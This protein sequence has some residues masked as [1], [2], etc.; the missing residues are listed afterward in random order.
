ML[1]SAADA[2][3]LTYAPGLTELAGT[4]WAATGI[5]NGKEAVVS[6]AGTEKATAVF[7]TD[8]QVSGTGGCNTFS[9]TYATTDP[10]GLT[11]GPLAATANGCESNTCSL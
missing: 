6:M 4:S 10:D 2:P 11:F 7:G 3:L 1:L 5:N 9:G 8:G